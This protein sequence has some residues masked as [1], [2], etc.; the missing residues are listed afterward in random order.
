MHQPFALNRTPSSRLQACAG[1]L[2][3]LALLGQAACG[4]GKAGDGSAGTPAP[5]PAA[6]VSLAGTLTGTA[7]SPLFNQQPLQVA[8]AP[9]TLNGAPVAA[10]HLQPGVI[11]VGKGI[12]NGQGITLQS[13]DLRTELK[14]LITSLDA[15]AAT[16]KVLDTVVTVNTLTLLEQEASEEVFTSLSFADLAV[17]DFVSVF[18][19]PQAGGGV[20]ATRV[21]REAPGAVDS[22]ELRGTVGS[23]D[24]TA[25]T[26]LLGTQPV[27]YATATVIGVLA[28]GAQV[29]VEGTL[30]GTILTASKV[31]VEEAMGH[32]EGSEVEASGALS[33]LDAT[34]KQFTLQALKVDYS[35]AIVEGTLAEG[36]MV[37]AEGVLSPTDPTVLVATK[38]EVRFSPMGNGASNLEAQGPIT[39]LGAVEL[40]L[41]VG[42]RVY[43]TDAQTLVLD[44]DAALRFDQLLVGDR[45]QVRALSTRTNAAGQ[46]YASRVERK[47]SGN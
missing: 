20:L 7:S 45:V 29:E 6:T 17:G 1:A 12:R 26:F 15:T 16:F 10:T 46:A 38:V 18:G 8:G 19:T 25:K 35:S 31:R 47:N 5:P 11:L 33:G 4:G 34:A 36:A 9:I 23:L 44:R 39:A 13:A 42:G 37:E 27:S 41:T 3:L 40:T 30:V 43:W 2:V 22:P 14:G 21:E 24:A 32:G 28:E